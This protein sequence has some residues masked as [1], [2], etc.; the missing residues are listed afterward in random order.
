MGLFD[1]LKKITKG[2]INDLTKKIADN[3]EGATKD[4]VYGVKGDI[5]KATGVNLGQTPEN[6]HQENKKEVPAMYSNFP[7]F[8]KAPNEIETKETEKYTRCS[9]TFYNVTNEEIQ[10]YI[11]KVQSQ[12][13]YKGSKVRYDKSNTY[14]IVDDNPSSGDL[15][16]VFHI[17][18]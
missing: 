1:E 10:S 6:M 11:L 3:I 17:K 16:I 8:G 7:Q 4:I 15:N 5:E 2:D 12:G 13:Y 9:M 18:K 14:V